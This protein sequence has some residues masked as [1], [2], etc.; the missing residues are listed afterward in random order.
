MAISNFINTLSGSFP[1]HSYPSAAFY[2]K[3]YFNSSKDLKKPPK[4]RTII[5]V[6]IY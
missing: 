6:V 4:G 3:F 1:Y 5:L 2:E